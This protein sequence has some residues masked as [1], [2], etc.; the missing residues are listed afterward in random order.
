MLMIVSAIVLSSVLYAQSVDVLYLKNGSII[1]GNVV[2]FDPT[3]GIKIQTLD[4]S[5]FVYTMSEIDHLSS[6]ESNNTSIT[7]NTVGNSNRSSVVGLIDR[8][9]SIFQWEDTGRDLTDYEYKTIF[10]DEL[11]DTYCSAHRQF[12][13]GRTLQFVSLGL[14]AVSTIFMIGS[15]SSG[16][17]EEFVGGM[18]VFFTAAN[19]TFA[20]G[21]IF[22]GIGKGRLEWIK[23]TYNGR[24]ISNSNTS[25]LNVAP[26]LMMTAQKDLG[27]GA[28]IVF[29]F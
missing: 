7:R 10:D 27:L 8:H 18:Y 22:K 17:A 23:N 20:T 25:S 21:S 26:T 28:S 5:L 2:E 24:I 11:Y 9:K 12:N 4:G 14:A 3:N 16:G 1:K 15:I 13:A 29:A 6:D 19:I